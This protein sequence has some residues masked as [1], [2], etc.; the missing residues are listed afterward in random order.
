MFYVDHGI[1]DLIARH[2]ESGPIDVPHKRLRPK[3]SDRRLDA[4]L[5]RLKATGSRVPVDVHREP[6]WP[7]ICRGSRLSRAVV[8]ARRS[9]IEQAILSLGGELPGASH[10][11]QV[12]PGTTTTWRGH[13]PGWAT[14]WAIVPA[15]AACYLV[16]ALLS[17]MRGE[18]VAALTRG[19]LRERRDA[20]GQLVRYEVVGSIFKGR[21]QIGGAFHR[22]VV[23]EPVARAILAARRIQD[24]FLSL[25]DPEAQAGDNDLLFVP[26]HL[27]DNNNRSLAGQQP[28]AYLNYFAAECERLTQDILSRCLPADAANITALYRIP[29]DDAGGRWHWQ[30]RQLRRTLAWY[31]ANQP[32]GVVAGMIQYGHASTVMFEGYA[33]SSASGFRAEIDEENRLARLADIV[34]VY[35]NWKHGAVPGGPMGPRLVA[36]FTA[37]SKDLGDLPGAVVSEKRRAKLLENT[38]VTLYPGFIND[39]FFYADHAL[40]L[41]RGN[42]ASGPALSRCQPQRCPNSMVTKRHEPALRACLEDAESMKEGKRLSPLQLR[43]ID[44]QI[45]TYRR[46]LKE[47]EA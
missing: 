26:I 36:E 38:A 40:C 28:T 33:G 7:E 6:S 22:W 30:T 11:W 2:R 39:C 14:H 5:N 43:A 42:E 35:E 31:I 23:I 3:V 34:E 16:V 47:A 12:L 24:H 13:L 37:V 18:E 9:K 45:E 4:Y 21:K 15:L 46:L 19:C 41:K 8:L 44:L 10:N 20:T 27:R 25:R 32:F 1:D 29:N 17:G